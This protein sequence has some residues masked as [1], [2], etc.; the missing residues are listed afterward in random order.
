MLSAPSYDG[1]VSLPSFLNRGC[2]QELMGCEVLP[3]PTLLLR[4]AV[5]SPTILRFACG[6]FSHTT[7]PPPSLPQ[8]KTEFMISTMEAKENFFLYALEESTCLM[9]FICNGNRPWTMNV[10]QGAQAGG[11]LVCGA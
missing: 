5:P 3:P 4:S 2:L 6:C 11:P 9:R 10:S 8:A 7:L 1:L